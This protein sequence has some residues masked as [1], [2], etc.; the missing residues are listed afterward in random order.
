MKNKDRNFLLSAQIF[1]F[2]MVPPHLD[3]QQVIRWD[4]VTLVL[5][6]VCQFCSELQ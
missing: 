3:H 2:V 5:R 1:R 6:L 4:F